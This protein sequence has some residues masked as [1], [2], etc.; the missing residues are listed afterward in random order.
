MDG[1]L[2]SSIPGKCILELDECNIYYSVV[3]NNTNKTTATVFISC[4]VLS[5][6]GGSMTTKNGLKGPRINNKGDKRTLPYDKLT[7]IEATLLSS[8][9]K[10]CQ[11]HCMFYSSLDN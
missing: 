7:E 3:K 2:P 1:V 8:R 6:N 11:N 9:S 4:W 10:I 5:K